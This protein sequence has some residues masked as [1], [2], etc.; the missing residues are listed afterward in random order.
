MATGIEWTDASWNP[1][2]GCTKVSAGCGNCYAIRMAHRLAKNPK[3]AEVGND[4]V[5]SGGD[6]SIRYVS[7]PYMDSTTITN[8]V[9]NWSGALSFIPSRLEQ[10]LRW[11]KPR[12]VFVC[13]MGDLFHESVPFEWVRQVM[14]VIERCPQHTFQLLTKRPARMLRFYESESGFLAGASAGH[15]WG[16]DYPKNAW[17]GV[18]VEDQATAGERIPL[19]LEVPAAVRFVSVEPLLSAVDVSPWLSAL[20][21]I[22]VGGESGPGARPMHHSWVRS[23]RDQCVESSTPFFFKQWGEWGS[24]DLTPDGR[25]QINPEYRRVGKK[26][27]GRFL[28]GRTWDEVPTGEES[29]DVS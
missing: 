14:E 3:I 25:G 5:R 12:R 27:A 17:L 16:W 26:A 28:D 2:V 24:Y 10:P 8:G 6:G 18:S 23:L 20:S 29:P 22:I 13:S 15:G 19:L 11:R 1:I 9:V 21:Q 7:N 4:W